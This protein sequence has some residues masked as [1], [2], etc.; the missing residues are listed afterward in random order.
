MRGLTRVQRRV[1]FYCTSI[2]DVK[3]TALRATKRAKR[4]P[5]EFNKHWPMNFG[6]MLRSPRGPRTRART[7]PGDTQ[8]FTSEKKTKTGLQIQKR[9]RVY[10]VLYGPTF[11]NDEPSKSLMTVLVE[12]GPW[13]KTLAS[14]ETLTGE[15]AKMKS[16]FA[17]RRY[18]TPDGTFGAIDH[19][20]SHYEWGTWLD[21][22]VQVVQADDDDRR[23]FSERNRERY[24][25]LRKLSPVQSLQAL[26][27][28][29]QGGASMAEAWPELRDYLE[30]KP[31]ATRGVVE[32]LKAG[33]VPPHSSA[34][35]YI[36]LGNA[37]TPQARDELL[38]IATAENA[39]AMSRTRAMFSLV[40]R[41][42]V[43]PDFA[44]TLSQQ[45][46]AITSGGD[47]N[48]RFIARESALALGA[49]AGLKGNPTVKQIAIETVDQMLSAAGN[50]AVYL[51]PA[52]STLAN[53]GDAKL[54][55]RIEPYT[56]S[57]I[58]EIR[59][60]ATVAIRRMHPK[61]T[62]AFVAEWLDR[63]TSPIVRQSL[64]KI[65]DRQT[66]DTKTP[67][68]PRLVTRSIA[69]L[70]ARPDRIT[71]KSIIRMLG[72]AAKTSKDAKQALL[73]QVPIELAKNDFGQY[74]S[75]IRHLE[76]DELREAIAQWS[77]GIQP[78][79][80]SMTGE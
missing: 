1:R 4:P 2:A 44:R 14:N 73:D 58:D 5:P 25:Q 45:T 23:P 12:S 34:L 79:T 7:P 30:A 21:R 60:A 70:K 36:A 71:S 33:H 51:R 55:S 20:L 38:G 64:Y 40:D 69:D 42:D 65:M 16:Q 67:L 57:S 78:T 18:K 76:P 46:S 29:V 43:G 63:E 10:D 59:D 6:G 37:K 62:E 26:V 8:R 24:E 54:L 68:S 32:H 61:D 52:F 22:Q 27:D 31:E 13:F 80:R 9:I 56:K 53:I 17:A 41:N 74:K 15:N 50:R 47:S 35:V 3:W 72:Q 75:I 39:P 49:M 48:G 28:R 66:H 77:H 11:Y 19:D